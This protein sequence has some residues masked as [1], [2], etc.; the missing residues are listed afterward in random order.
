MEQTKN[1]YA[2]AILHNYYGKDTPPKLYAADENNT[3]VDGY[4]VF[5]TIGEAAEMVDEW[6]TDDYV[7][8]HGEAGR[9]D[10]YIVEDHDAEYVS[11]GRGGDESNYN[12]DDCD[13]DRNDGDCCGECNT[14][15]ELMIE[16]D[17]QYIID[18]A[19]GGAR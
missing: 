12:W 15:L 4:D 3:G 17:R 19:I 8:A 1:L 11:G 18:N 13:C 6:N 9:P 14:C 16:Q 10:Y 5:D 2:I 7:C